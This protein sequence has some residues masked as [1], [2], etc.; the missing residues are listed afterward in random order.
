MDSVGERNSQLQH[1]QPDE[2]E[3]LEA[4]R[5]AKEMK[6]ADVTIAIQE[7]LRVKLWLTEKRR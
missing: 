5:K 2:L 4:Y 3:V 6:F 1:V 7:G